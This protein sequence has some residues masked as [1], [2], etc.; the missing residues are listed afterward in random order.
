MTRTTAHATDRPGAFAGGSGCATFPSWWT[1]CL[2]PAVTV[3]APATRT[4]THPVRWDHGRPDGLRGATAQ[5]GAGRREGGRGR[6]PDQLAHRRAASG[7]RAIREHPHLPRSARLSR[8]RGC[9]IRSGASDRSG[10]T[11]AWSWSTGRGFVVLL[12]EDGERAAGCAL[13]AHAS[14]GGAPAP[15][16]NRKSWLANKPAHSRYPGRETTA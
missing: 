10:E 5:G 13:S 16:A 4:T 6:R 14:L 9:T 7:H 8:R 12:Q 1:A 11:I 15:R 2:A 3:K